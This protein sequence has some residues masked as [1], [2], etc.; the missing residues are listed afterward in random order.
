[1][2][3]VTLVALEAVSDDVFVVQLRT[4][5]PLPGF[6]AGQYLSL[7]AG[8]LPASYFS[9]A[10]RPGAETLELHIQAGQVSQSAQQLLDA[11][12]QQQPAWITPPG[13]D[14]HYQRLQAAEQII[15]V[16]A[17]TG[18]SQMK[19]VIEHWAE[20]QDPRP[21][22]LYWSARQGAGLYQLALVQAWQQQWPGFRFSALI[23]PGLQWNGLQGALDAVILAENPDLHRAAVMV[24]GSAAMVWHTHDV[25]A[26]AGLPA[27]R[28]FS[29]VFAF[30]PRT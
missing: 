24:C 8:D 19:S 22:S 9:I 28:I 7:Q 26:A 27:G 30:Q 17:S 18:F 25:M 23:S 4:E 29:D 14:C 2:I 3:A 6:E 1:M 15:L 21:L 10:S 11:L 12:C 5:E 13:G 20:V 16:C